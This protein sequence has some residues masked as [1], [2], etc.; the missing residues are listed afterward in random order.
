VRR[1]TRHDYDVPGSFSRL[2][3]AALAAADC[4]TDTVN[5][6][7]F[8]SACQRLRKAA[9]AYGVAHPES[10]HAYA[11]ARAACGNGTAD[12]SGPKGLDLLA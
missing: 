7:E 8:A 11:E 4:D 1:L 2:L 3:E 10:I 6:P 9:V 5:D 12:L